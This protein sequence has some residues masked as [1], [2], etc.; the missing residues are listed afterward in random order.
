MRC[1]AIHCTG[2]Q[3]RLIASL[4]PRSRAAGAKMDRVVAGFSLSCLILFGACT[5]SAGTPQANT[6]IQ[7]WKVSDKCASQAQA[8]FPDFTAESNAKREASLKACLD[9]QML[10]PREKLSPHN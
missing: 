2:V 9:S 8:A 5:A 1:N 3:N 6:V 7:K 4:R 10:P